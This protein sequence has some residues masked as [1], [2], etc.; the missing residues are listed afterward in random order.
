MQNN[1]AIKKPLEAWFL[2][3]SER[4]WGFALGVAVTLISCATGSV[5][6]GVATSIAILAIDIAYTMLSWRRHNTEQ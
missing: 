1:H 3:W 5:T 2:R 4:F 6:V